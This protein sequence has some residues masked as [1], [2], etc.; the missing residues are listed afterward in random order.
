V[1]FNAAL[2]PPFVRRSQ[3]FSAALPW[4]YLKG[5]STGD[6]CEALTILVGDAAK[7]P[8]PNVPLRQNSCRL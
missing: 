3:R 5:I 2:V 7:G 1:K 4:L 8:S 6:M